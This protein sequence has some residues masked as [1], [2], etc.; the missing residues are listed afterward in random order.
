MLLINN[1]NY[2]VNRLLFLKTLNLLNDFIGFIFSHLT[3]EP[4]DKLRVVEYFKLSDVLERFK[5]FDLTKIFVLKK[6]LSILVI[7]KRNEILV[8]VG[9]RGVFQ[10]GCNKIFLYVSYFLLVLTD[11]IAFFELIAES[12]LDVRIGVF[13]LF[14]FI[15]YLALD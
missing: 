15:F 14:F 8:F 10:V 5:L 13:L 4:G 7:I 11:L 1:F 9:D 2:L 6:L 12:W 3:L